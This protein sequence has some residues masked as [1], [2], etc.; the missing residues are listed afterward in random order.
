[1]SSI[2]V[3]LSEESPITLTMVMLNV[4]MTCIAFDQYM[5]SSMIIHAIQDRNSETAVHLFI[6]IDVEY[7]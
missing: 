4:L 6:I 3:Y 7:G 5:L 1:M 2:P